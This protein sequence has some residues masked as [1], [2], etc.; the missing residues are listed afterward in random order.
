VARGAGTALTGASTAGAGVIVLARPRMNRILD[1]RA[2]DGVAVAEPVPVPA[3][4]AA[5]EIFELALRPGGTVTGEHG[6][7]TL[8]R[9]WLAA[10][11]AR[12]TTTC[13]NS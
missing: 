6:V 9:A 11:S 7:G 12:P 5:D 13:R 2:D 10:S 3:A 8:K 1:L 4:R